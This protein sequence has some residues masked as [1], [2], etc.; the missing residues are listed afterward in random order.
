MNHK[1]RVFLV[2]LTTL[3]AFISATELPGPDKHEYLSD[4]K[5]L[6]GGSAAN[7]AFSLAQLG[8]TVYLCTR[9][10]ADIAG[11]IVRAFVADA[12][13]DISYL[14]EDSARPTGF[15]VI[16]VG[17]SGKIGLLHCEGANAAISP[18][19]IP[20]SAVKDCDILHVGGAMSLE[21]LDGQP[22]AEL[23]NAVKSRSEKL[24]SLHTSRNTDRKETLVPC[25][26]YLD[27]LFTNDKEA[28]DITRQGNAVDSANW[29]H[30][31][32][33]TIVVITQGP[34]GAY[35]SDKLSSTTVPAFH[36][37]VVDTTGCGDAFAAGFL[38]AALRGHS[39][40]ESATWGN[41]LGAHCAQTTGAMP[42]PFNYSL[43]SD[44][45]RRRSTVSPDHAASNPL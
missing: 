4:Y 7:M 15:S 45:V 23:F 34:A 33:V 28:F 26:P 31:H 35:A 3:D 24:T 18:Q 37:D 25:L 30:D 29:F 20:W 1:V 6:P 41:A 10:G 42:Y 17:S 16:S 40:I 44:L 2:G 32:G 9:V 43:V 8:A 11:R 36:I 38:Y 5:L 12:G 21:L 19:D 13:I 27:Y 22:L 14:S 39:L